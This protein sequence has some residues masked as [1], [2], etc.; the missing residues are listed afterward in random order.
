MKPVS[1]MCLIIVW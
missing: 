1:L